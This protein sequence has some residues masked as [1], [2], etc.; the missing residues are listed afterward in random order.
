MCPVLLCL[1]LALPFALWGRICQKQQQQAEV[2][3]GWGWAFSWRFTLL[4]GVVHSGCRAHPRKHYRPH[5]PSRSCLTKP[6][7][8]LICYQI[9]NV[10]TLKQMYCYQHATGHIFQKENSCSLNLSLLFL[11]STSNTEQEPAKGCFPSHSLQACSD[12]ALS[13]SVEASRSATA[14]SGLQSELDSGAWAS[15]SEGAESR[16]VLVH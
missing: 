15:Q 14:Q 10:G 1:Y 8:S 12:A 11:L 13:L 3:R 16:E 5:M 7:P 2:A 9:P 6:L 4:L